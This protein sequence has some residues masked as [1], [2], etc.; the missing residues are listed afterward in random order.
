MLSVG[1][2]DFGFKDLI[3]PE[4]GRVRVLLSALI[5]FAKFREEQ[6]SILEEINKRFDTAHNEQYLLTIKISEAK[7]KIQNL[8]ENRKQEDK[9]AKKIKDNINSLIFD[10]KEQK[11]LQN[12]LQ[13]QLEI[14]KTSRAQNLQKIEL[15]RSFIETLKKDEL[16]LRSRIVQNPEVLQNALL[17]MTN[18]VQSDRLNLNIL[19][20]KSRDLE[21]KLDLFNLF[22]EDLKQLILNYNE[23][24]MI[25][26]K[27]YENTRNLK[28][29]SDLI[30]RINN[31]LKDFSL[32]EM[33]LIRKLNIAEEKLKKLHLQQEEKRERSQSI[34]E[35]LRI[36][37]D[38]IKSERM[39]LMNQNEVIEKKLKETESHV[40][41]LIILDGSAEISIFQRDKFS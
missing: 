16:K 29:E 25:K 35:D 20:K 24:S 26:K 19:D 21:S 3:K 4:F 31:T 30:D 11:K 37:Y 14:I 2:N 41:K 1:I 34:Q 40:S 8:E 10:L 22:Y 27:K 9:E 17:D 12:S 5:N 6:L 38:S 28:T 13:N 33:H 7:V 15:L 39:N 32:K 36:S 23:Y 18:V